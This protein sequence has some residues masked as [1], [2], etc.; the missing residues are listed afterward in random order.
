[1]LPPL[2]IVSSRACLA[3]A[4]LRRIAPCH[5][6]QSLDLLRAEGG[7]HS[8]FAEFGQNALNA[9]RASENLRRSSNWICE[10]VAT[11]SKQILIQASE[12]VAETINLGSGKKYEVRTARLNCVRA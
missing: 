4:S 10:A 1:M 2:G 11:K 5:P 6:S 9:Q 12:L 3:F 7:R 8:S